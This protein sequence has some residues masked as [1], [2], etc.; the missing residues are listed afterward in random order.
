MI[1]LFDRAVAAGTLVG[2]GSGNSAPGRLNTLRNMLLAARTLLEAGNVAAAC[3]QLLDAANRT[4]GLSPPP[5]FV[6]GAAAPQLFGAITTVRG[7]LGC[8]P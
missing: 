2:Q 4:D 8:V 6:Q 7:D 1:A 3:G 5:D